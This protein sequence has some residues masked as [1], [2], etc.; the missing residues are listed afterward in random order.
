VF[1]ENLDV[2]S[3]VRR[4]LSTNVSMSIGESGANG[5]EA[6]SGYMVKRISA[7]GGCLGSQRR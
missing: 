1:I 6:T 3:V 2:T 7:Y 5:P 4:I